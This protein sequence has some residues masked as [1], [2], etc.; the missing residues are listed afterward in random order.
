MRLFSVKRISSLILFTVMTDGEA[1]AGPSP[2]YFHFSFPVFHIECNHVAVIFCANQSNAHSFND[3]RRHTS[4]K[5]WYRI[6]GI[7]F[8]PQN[9]ARSCIKHDRMPEMPNVTIL[10]FAYAG[11]APW[12]GCAAAGPVAAATGYLST[13]TSLPGG[14]NRGRGIKPHRAIPALVLLDRSFFRRGLE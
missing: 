14:C 12:T 8:S 11:S 6:C 5:L 1:Y 4:I 10:P 9:F 7:F 2:V 3:Q 13:Q